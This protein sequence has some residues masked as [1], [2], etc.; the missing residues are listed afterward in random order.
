[1]TLTSAGESAFHAE[2][3]SKMGDAV[4]CLVACDTKRAK[5]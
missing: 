4:S 3:L 1:M 2:A 5:V